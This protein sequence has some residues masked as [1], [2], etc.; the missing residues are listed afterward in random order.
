MLPRDHSF[1][2]ERG[3]GAEVLIKSRGACLELKKI[4]GV[5]LRATSF[6]NLCLFPEAREMKGA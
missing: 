6:H 3:Y 5:D 1:W 2:G 4:R